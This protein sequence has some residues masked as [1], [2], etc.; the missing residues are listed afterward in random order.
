MRE[1]HVRICERLGVKFP[2]P[3]RQGL[4]LRS[5][6]R[7]GRCASNSY[8]LPRPT[9]LAALGHFP[10][11]AAQQGSSCSDPGLRAL[12]RLNLLPGGTT[13]A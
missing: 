4:P 9:K 6:R 11:H 5:R 1:Y 12:N 8:R 10:T 2:G 3:T 7:H 13:K